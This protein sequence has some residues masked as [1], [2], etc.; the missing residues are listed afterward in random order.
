MKSV[1][2]ETKLDPAGSGGAVAIFNEVKIFLMTAGSVINEII[3][4]FDWQRAHAKISI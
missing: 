4:I 1:C 2:C 3:C